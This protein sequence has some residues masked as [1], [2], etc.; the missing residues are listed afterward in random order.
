[1]LRTCTA[2]RCLHFYDIEDLVTV[3]LPWLKTFLRLRSGATSHNNRNRVFQ[4]LDPK[5]F[6][7]CMARWTQSK[8][9]V[10]GGERVALDG[11]AIRRVH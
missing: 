11:K 2:L 8:R 6:G 4:A 7:E 3:R 5:E 10:P 1:M 9:T